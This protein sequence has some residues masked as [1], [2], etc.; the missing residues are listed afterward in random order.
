METGHFSGFFGI[1]TQ[2]PDSQHCNMGSPL[3]QGVGIHRQ[4]RGV[5]NH[6]GI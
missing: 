4:E 3:R 2:T 1:P 5:Q 6:L